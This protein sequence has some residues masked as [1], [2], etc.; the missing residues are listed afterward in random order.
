M[1]PRLRAANGALAA[2]DAAARTLG[3]DG[4]DGTG[5]GTDQGEAPRTP[6]TAAI[7]SD[8]NICLFP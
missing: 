5:A 7:F 4:L 8:L 6:T 3:T 2:L 1:L